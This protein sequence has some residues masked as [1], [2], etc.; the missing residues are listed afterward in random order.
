[1][2]HIVSTMHFASTVNLARADCL[3]SSRRA[4]QNRLHAFHSSGCRFFLHCN[5]LNK[6]FSLSAHAVRTLCMRV[7][8]CVGAP[9]PAC[10]RATPDLKIPLIDVTPSFIN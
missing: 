4:P 1:M 5:Y 10:V 9:A 3:T 8:V 6:G 7:C 2:F